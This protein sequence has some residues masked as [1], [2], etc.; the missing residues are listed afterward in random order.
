MM[1]WKKLCFLILAISFNSIASGI[2]VVDVAAI[3]KTVEEGVA[4]AQEAANQL[5]QLKQQYEQAMKYAEDQ[6]KRLE[7]FSD[8]SNGFDS[9]SSYMQ[10]SLG[11]IADT[12]KSN[13]SG[14]RGEYGLSSS[15]KTAQSR[16][17]ALLQKIKFYDD[18]NSSMND[19]ATR[20]T[21]LQN[22]FSSADTPQKKAD[23]ANQLNIEKM[24]LDMQIKQ[25]DL[26]EKQMDSSE[27][28]RKES[29]SIDFFKN[30]LKE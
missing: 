24:T 19:R 9:A 1:H 18:F 29:V 30:T 27:K 8:F 6:K 2:P 22:A 28:A 17:D 10:N 5:S 11:D 4:R 15:D 12:A 14:L 13:L 7:G 25:Y 26:A 16:Y 20:L 3:A 23:L 21:K